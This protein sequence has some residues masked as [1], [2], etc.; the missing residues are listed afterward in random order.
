M[1]STKPIEQIRFLS[2]KTVSQHPTYESLPPA[3]KLLFYERYQN[4]IIDEMRYVDSPA[5][6][7]PEATENVYQE[8]ASLSTEFGKI[9]CFGIGL[10][11]DGK[12]VVQTT[13]IDDEKE[14]LRQVLVKT[15]SSLAAKEL[16]K[17]IEFCGHAI[18]SFHFP[19]LA[20]RMI[21]N[22]IDPPPILDTGHLKPWETVWLLDTLESWKMQQ[23]DGN[24][25]LDLLCEVFGI[26]RG[27]QSVTGK[28]INQVY[29][30]DKN[31][32]EIEKYCAD[33]L[34]MLAQVYCKMKNLQITL[35]R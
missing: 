33:S 3:L 13:C 9:I 20:K 4:A 35:T 28:T 7:K 18:K 12:F 24:T 5:A 8:K 2:I 26:R 21:I 27:T 34:F 29:Y 30:T 19:F 22:G 15:P 1:L 11:K 23:W 32:P 16:P 25:S 17:A 10:V 31:L 6:F 14:L